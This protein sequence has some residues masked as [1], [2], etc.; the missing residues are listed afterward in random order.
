MYFKTVFF[1][2]FLLWLEIGALNMVPK[3]PA[4]VPT[5]SSFI[6]DCVDVM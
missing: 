3:F 6:A 2:V 4:T 1:P 5:Y